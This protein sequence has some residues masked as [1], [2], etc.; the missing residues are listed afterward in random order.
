LKDAIFRLLNVSLIL[1]DRYVVKNLTWEIKRGEN[2]VLIGPNGAGKTSLLSIINGYRWPS[3]GRV[4][5]LGREFGRTDL[6][7]LRTEV[8]MVSTYLGE[9][10][11]RNERVIDLVLSGKYGSVRLWRGRTDSDVEY[12]ESLMK[13]MSCIQFKDKRVGDLSQGERQEVLIARA[14][15]GRPK[16]LTLD[17]PCEGLD[18]RARES[19][20]D[21]ISNLIAKRMVSIVDVTHRTDEIPKGFTHALLLDDGKKVAAGHIEE[22]ITA[23]NLSRCFGVKVT[24]KKWG[25]RYYTVAK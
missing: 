12:A 10:V 6:R 2:W 22:V 9:W 16:L 20:L 18:L 3:Y 25:G 14:L 4:S 24:V 5:V 23:E 1:D 21:S 15:M 19:F 11:S 7:E 13:L 8:G 17:E